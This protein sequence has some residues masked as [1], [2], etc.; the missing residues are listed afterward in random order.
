MCLAQNISL[1]DTN[2]PRSQA[3]SLVTGPRI[4]LRNLQCEKAAAPYTCYIGM[5]SI[6]LSLMRCGSILTLTRARQGEEQLRKLR[7][8]DAPAYSGIA[9]RSARD[10]GNPCNERRSLQRSGFSRVPPSMGAGSQC[11]AYHV[12]FHVRKVNA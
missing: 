5:P 10:T 4:I 7:R 2:P 3:V 8:E 11:M 6:S 9:D 12:N 1:S